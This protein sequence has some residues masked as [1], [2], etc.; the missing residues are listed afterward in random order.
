MRIFIS[1]RKGYMDIFEEKRQLI[2]KIA[3]QK[4]DTLESKLELKQLLLK[5][6]NGGKLYKYRSFDKDGYSLKNLEEGTLHCSLVEAFNDPFDSKFGYSFEALYKTQ[7]VDYEK[8][9][10]KKIYIFTECVNVLRGD[11]EINNYT[12]EQKENIKKLLKNK[13]LQDF[14]LKF[15]KEKIDKSKLNLED[16][17]KYIIQIIKIVLLDEIKSK[18][19][20]TEDVLKF[21]LG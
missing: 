15:K 7:S 3:C 11:S 18:Y 8:E 9:I 21:G 17:K 19:G 1:K 12:N 4:E 20:V 13:E 16:N 6:T 5:D 2:E 14:W 10:N